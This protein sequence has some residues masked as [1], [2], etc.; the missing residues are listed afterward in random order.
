MA[1]VVH[2]PATPAQRALAHYR[3]EERAFGVVLEV[4]K[5]SRRGDD[6][7]L[8]VFSVY[9]ARMMHLRR[10]CGAHL[11]GLELRSAGEELQRFSR[12]RDP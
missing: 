10:L 1:G 5:G 8:K 3:E 2:L 9:R 6:L 11:S 12:D 7:F 4:L